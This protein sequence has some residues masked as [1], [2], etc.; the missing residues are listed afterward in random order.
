MA[1]MN[2]AQFAAELKMPATALFEQLAK[3][4]VAKQASNDTLSRAGQDAAARLPAQGPRRDRA[5]GQDHADA[6]ADHRNQVG[7]LD[8]QGAH[9]PGR[10]A[11][12]A[13]LRQA[14][15]GTGRRGDG[16]RAHGRGGGAGASGSRVP[17]EVGGRARSAGTR[18]GGRDVRAARRIDCRPADH[19]QGA[20]GA[21]RS[22]SQAP[23]RTVG[24]PGGGNQ[25]E[26]GARSQRPS[27]DA[28]AR[29][30]QQQAELARKA[31]RREKAK[32]DA[33]GVSGTLHKPAAKPGEEAKKPGV[34]KATGSTWKDDAAQEAW[35]QDARRYRRW[36]RWL[37][38]RPAGPPR[39]QAPRGGR[40]RQ[41]P[42]EAIVREVHVPGN[43]HASPI[44]RTRCRSRPPRS[45]RP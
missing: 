32:A 17:V 15:G 29:L 11:Q 13:G 45:S 30:A 8:R 22:R 43:H 35:H 39:R 42:V 33:G 24:D 34:K 28:E 4:G 6:Q 40:S 12:E 19:R 7:R 10:G 36:R 26:A 1:Q 5:E 18:R 9:H 21:A 23:G 2:V 16:A 44:W 27:A 37:A 41:Q 14:R 25:G 20:V 3:A 38:W 31:G